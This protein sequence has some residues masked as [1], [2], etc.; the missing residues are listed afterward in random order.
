LA[1]SPAGAGCSIVSNRTC[2]RDLDRRR[3][4]HRLSYVHR[5]NSGSDVPPETLHRSRKGMWGSDFNLVPK[6]LWVGKKGVCPV[7]DQRSRMRKAL[8][9]PLA[10][11]A[12]HESLTRAGGHSA[13]WGFSFVLSNRTRCMRPPPNAYYTACGRWQGRTKVHSR[14][15]GCGY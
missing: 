3:L 2:N 8:L 6:V 11:L 10:P 14:H 5:P 1:V 7:S 9:A 12:P 15:L 13:G 4:L